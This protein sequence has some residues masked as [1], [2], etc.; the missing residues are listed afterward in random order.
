MRI[1]ALIDDRDVIERILR[2][3]G[4]WAQS[5]CVSPAR[6]QPE[7]AEGVVEPCFDEPFPGYDIELVMV[8][9]DG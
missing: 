8:F 5:N 2:H 4:L 1:V 9:A 3:L 7:I 6:A